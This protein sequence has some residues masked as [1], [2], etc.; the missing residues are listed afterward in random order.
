MEHRSWETSGHLNIDFSTGKQADER[1][2]TLEQSLAQMWHEHTSK[3]VRVP[4]ILSNYRDQSFTTLLQWCLGIFLIISTIRLVMV[5][6]LPSPSGY[7]DMALQASMTG[8][9]VVCMY[10]QKNQHPTEAKFLFLSAVLC[11]MAF[12]VL[13]LEEDIRMAP[14]LVLTLLPVVAGMILSPRR[15]RAWGFATLCVWLVMASLRVALLSASDTPVTFEVVF[16]VIPALLIGIIT[17]LIGITTKYLVGAI[18]EVDSARKLA[19]T[20]AR[21][22][23]AREQAEA[24]SAA[25]SAFLANMSHELRTP[26]NAIIGYSDLLIQQSRTLGADHNEL[27]QIQQAGRHLLSL[28]NDILDFSKVESG[29]MELY[30]EDFD[31]AKTIHEVAST[32]RVLVE[33]NNNVLSLTLAPGLGLMSSDE[34]KVRQCLYNLISNAAKFT[35]N[36]R[37]EVEARRSKAATG[38]TIDF[39][40]RDNG[41]GISEEQLSR[42]F[43]P[44]VQGD[45]SITRKYGGSGLGL[46]LTYRYCRLLGGSVS[47]ASTLGKGATFTVRLPATSEQRRQPRPEDSLHVSA[48]TVL[49]IVDEHEFE[50]TVLQQI[51]G[52]GYRTFLAQGADEGIKL[53]SELH[54]HIIVLDC[55]T[56]EAEQWRVLAD[57]K[58]NSE[59]SHT[60]LIMIADA[61]LRERAQTLGADTFLPHPADPQKILDHLAR[62]TQRL[63]H[64][65]LVIEDDPAS[66]TLMRQ[67]LAR[68]G[69]TCR[70]AGDGFEGLEQLKQRI[71]QLIFLDLMMPSMD[72]FTFLERLR[73]HQPWQKIPVVV[74]TAKDLTTDERRFLRGRAVSIQRKTAFQSN[75]IVEEVERLLGDDNGRR[76]LSDSFDGDPNELT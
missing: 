37:I 25:K 17:L 45:S 38:D 64:D 28:I 40:V 69:W 23:E 58:T 13:V 61:S 22:R 49:L 16:I 20:N 62:Y 48:P 12:T 18:D 32:L 1:D 65:I 53:A 74:V 26:L 35:R 56:R 33:Q 14:G 68:A 7:I 30:V 29:R 52:H 31:V 55:F 71:P 39:V 54:P 59:Q 15:A 24:M 51:R 27:D 44:F 47:V 11:D 72:G 9:L 75:E 5:L 21:L 57:L 50:A 76:S 10:L 63:G 60:P 36:G 19:V 42:M 73:D 3:R 34:I 4:A 67:V 70:T 66:R 43:Q 6:E 41:I 46:A 2:N 8:L